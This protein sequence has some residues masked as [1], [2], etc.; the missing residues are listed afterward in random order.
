MGLSIAFLDGDARRVAEQCIA[1][2]SA[3]RDHLVVTLSGSHAYG[4]PSV[5]SDLDLKAIHVEPTDHLLGLSDPPATANRLEVINGVEIDYTSNE[6][7]PVL[8]G[9]LAGNGNYIERVLGRLICARAP[10]LDDLAALTR[11]A[12]SRRVHRHYRGFARSQAGAL[13]EA[14]TPTAKKLLYV[15][16]TALTGVHLLTTGELETDLSVTASLYGFDG[17]DQLIAHKRQ[18]ERVALATGDR[19]RWR[20]SVDRAF[21]LLDDARERSPLPEEPANSAEI[22]AWLVRFRRTR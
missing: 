6:L 14:A 17:V 2:E 21:A 16:R 19:D 4:F 1:E 20:R 11:D 5:D 8:A 3:R 9:I 7:G 13:D 10:A 12:L 22:E 15:L 18:N